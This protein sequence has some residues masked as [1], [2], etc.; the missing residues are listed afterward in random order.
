MLSFSPVIGAPAAVVINGHEASPDRVIVKWKD[1]ITPRASL[2]EAL[3]ANKSRNDGLKSLAASMEI[4]RSFD[5]LPGIAVLHLPHSLANRAQS[6]AAGTAAL[7]QGIEALE[8]SGLFEYVQPDYVVHAS[9]MPTDAAFTDGRL[10]G[11]RNTG[12][13]GGVAGMDIAATTAWD[14]TT[15]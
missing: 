11:L 8:T 1:G 7:K 9:R 3:G 13:N 2:A 4:E 14:V 10:W 12:Q 6:A 5:K 15:G